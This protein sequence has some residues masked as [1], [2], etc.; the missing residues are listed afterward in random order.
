MQPA[1]PTMES[2]PL[3]DATR[4]HRRTVSM[5]GVVL[6]AAFAVFDAATMPGDP[7]LLLTVRVAWIAALLGSWWLVRPGSTAGARWPEALCTI[8]STSAA[9]LAV[10]L[11]GGPNSG[12]FGFLFALPFCIAV[13]L[14]GALWGA[15]TAGVVTTAG[16][17]AFLVAAHTPPLEIVRW[18]ATA[19][20]MAILATY[21]TV[22]SRRVFAARLNVERA[23]AQLAEELAANVKRLALAER[24]ATAGRLA[25][26]VAH[27]VNNPLAFLRTNLEWIREHLASAAPLRGDMAEALADATHGVERI[28]RIVADL[29]GFCSP[30]PE[31]PCGTPV[32]GAVDE[33]LRIVSHRLD[34]RVRIQVDAPCD[35]PDARVCRARLVQVL[36]NLVVNAAEAATGP[37]AAPEARVS[38]HASSDHGRV[39]IAV[40]DSGPGL[41]ADVLAHLFE[42]F[43]TTKPPGRGTGLGLAL[44]REY[45]TTARGS[46]EASNQPGGGARF[47]IELFPAIA[48]E[49]GRCPSCTYRG[50]A[51]A[52]AAAPLPPGAATLA[53]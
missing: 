37:G 25:A 21:A 3:D 13:L 49:A 24:L 34:P 46:L 30:A 43:F 41:P 17:A 51:N 16:G 19:L 14:P 33:A 28:T 38:I 40:E 53:G 48:E 32:R 44:A 22:A 31:I 39:R 36:G 7:T 45:V 18:V 27:E 9:L 5:L 29:R 15:A 4:A 6:V 42:P 10:A 35:L 47:V 1:G 11:T 50:G 20:G 26:G 2:L 8:G 23:R 12:Y 52:A